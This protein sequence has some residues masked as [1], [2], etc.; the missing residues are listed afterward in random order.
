M[1]EFNMTCRHRDFHEQCLAT[2][3]Q[4]QLTES[5]DGSV[6]CPICRSPAPHNG[7][8]LVHLLNRRRNSHQMDLD[9]ILD[10]F[11]FLAGRSTAAA[12]ANETAGFFDQFMANFTIVITRGNDS[13]PRIIILPRSSN[14]DTVHHDA[15]SG[16][17]NSGEAAAADGES[18]SSHSYQITLE[19]ETDEGIDEDEDEGIDDDESIE[20]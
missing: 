1:L 6:T 13:S 3:F 11:L 8:D 12:A 4:T 18:L 15:G 14:N 16:D 5:E 17:H 2:W 9:S 20:E 7:Y 10:F 19:V